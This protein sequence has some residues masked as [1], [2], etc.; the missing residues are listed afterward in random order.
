MV[1]LALVVGLTVGGLRL[2]AVAADPLGARI[3]E[4]VEGRAVLT[5]APRGRAPLRFAEAELLG[6][7]VAASCCAWRRGRHRTEGRSSA[8]KDGWPGRAL[9]PTTS[10]SGRGSDGA[11]STPCCVST[12]GRCSDAATV[13]PGGST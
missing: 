6:P 2:D 5:S 7:P 9:R 4:R 11:A 1:A 13:R 10:T 3:G 8:S 12:T